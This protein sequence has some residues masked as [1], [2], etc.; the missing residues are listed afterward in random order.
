MSM[1]TE[2]ELFVGFTD[3]ERAALE[4]RL[5]PR[6]FAA[7]GVLLQQGQFSAEL[8]II[9]RGAVSVRSSDS[10]GKVS[11]LAQLGPG[12]FVG[13]MSLLTGQPHS[14]T[15]T[16]I[17]PTESLVLGRDDFLALLGNSPRLAQNIS[18]VLSE[19]LTRTNQQQ[20]KAPRT[21]IVAVACPPLPAAGPALAINLAVSLSLHTFR[22]TLLAVDSA[23][24][25]G[26][27]AP[28]CAMALPSLADV[29][30]DQGAAGA[31]RRAVPG[32][33]ALPG[34][35]LCALGDAGSHDDALQVL[36]GCYGQIVLATVDPGDLAWASGA[37]HCLIVASAREVTAGTLASTL[38]R[39]AQDGRRAGVVLADLA[40]AASVG[41]LQGLGAQIGTPILRGL[42]IQLDALADEGLPPLVRRERR[43][44]VATEIGRLAR[45]LAGCKVGLALGAGSARGFAHLGVLR[46]FERE[47]ITV[48]ALAGTSIGSVV[49]G[50]WATGMSADNIGRTLRAVGPR[51]LPPTLPYVSLF[52]NRNV[53]AALRQMVGEAHIDDLPIP[54]AA[55]AVDLHTR[56]PVVL[57]DGLLWKAMLASAAIPG[58]YPPVDHD[59]HLLIDGAVRDPLPTE[60]AADL[61]ADTVI[62]VRLSPTLEGEAVARE[63]TAIRGA[64]LLDIMLTMLDVMQEAIEGH[65]S[66]RAALVIHPPVAKVTIRQFNAGS[67]LVEAGARATE[68][69]L[70]TLRRLL[71][72][73]DRSRPLVF[74]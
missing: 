28:L 39:A 14:A 26:P 5:R 51:L 9:R 53:R 17:S 46:I 29:A 73:I 23:T 34:V 22:R 72:W 69:A 37:H 67:A 50:A 21:T 2:G 13:E 33:P 74:T 47:E 57:H 27:L 68:A 31:H 24:L 1:V 45:H 59:G 30:R 63:L 62:G 3:D 64:N 16:A 18:R 56:S 71:P 66:Q 40:H 55:V 10:L 42:T 8:H 48:D 38:A 4:V 20:V 54:F 35:S 15:V 25:R 70:P 36:E 11:E 44:A 58:I 65:G 19:R 49:A 7:G 41:L 52:S 61:G 43:G 60:V 6:S 12:Q 32:H